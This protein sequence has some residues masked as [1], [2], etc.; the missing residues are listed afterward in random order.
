VDGKRRARPQAFAASPAAR[1]LVRFLPAALLLGLLARQTWRQQ[2]AYRDSEAL[3][4]DV[5]VKNPASGAAHFHLGKIRTSQGRTREAT[6]HFHEAL[7]LQTD[8]TELYIIHTLLANSLVREGD[9]AGAREA[10]EAALKQKPDF[11]EALNGLGNLLARQ[12]QVDPAI[13]LYRRAL[14]VAPDQAAVHH[15]LANALAV[16]GDLVQAENHYR[17]SI[18]LD[19]K[20]AM[21]HM[22]YGNLLARLHRNAEAE[23]EFF[24]ALAIDP[25]FEAAQRNLERVREAQQ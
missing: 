7:R 23:V 13:E 19:R 2:S 21:T 12:G 3:W 15:N 6:R 16:K 1:W 8:D 5:L 25:G 18:R 17:E 24:A 14:E 10:F 9:T 11:W 20:A 4:S 22:N